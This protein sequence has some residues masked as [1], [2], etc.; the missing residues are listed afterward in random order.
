MSYTVELV[1][2]FPIVE[3]LNLNFFYFFAF[4]AKIGDVTPFKK[5]KI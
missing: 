5:W 3:R 2:K 1:I 4:F